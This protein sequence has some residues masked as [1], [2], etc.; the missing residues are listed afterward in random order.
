[1][2]DA[3]QLL[4]KIASLRMRLDQGVPRLGAPAAAGGTA[5]IE[6][7][8]RLG[9]WHN[10]LLDASLRTPDA[11]ADGPLPSRLTARGARVLRQSRELL[12]ALRALADDPILH[13]DEDDPLALLHHDC[14]ALLEVV[15][16][17][18]QAFP[19]VPSV[20]LRLCEGLE[21]VLS[22][23]EE[24]MA[25][26]RTALTHRRN[27]QERIDYLAELLRRL[28]V[29]QSVGLGPLQALAD[30]VAEEAQAGLPLRFLTAGPDD[31]ARFAAAHGL[32]TAQVL[33]RL[34]VHEADWQT[35]VQTALMAALVHDVGMTRVPADIL[36]QPGPLSDGQR[37]LVERHPALGA[38]MVASLWPGGGWPTEA[39]TDHH[40]RLDGTGYPL[41]RKD[42]Q[43]GSFARLLAACD[44]YAALCTA[45]P[46]RAAGDTR[47][48]LTD[49]LLMAEHG[50]LDRGCTDRLLLLSFF[51][52][53]SAV[54]LDDGAVAVVTG[55][56]ADPTR[57]MVQLVTDARGVPL[58]LPRALD[59]ATQPR[60]AVARSLPRSERRRVLLDKFPQ[61]V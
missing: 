52:I 57:P 16:R 1:M 29:G 21:V 33:A 50:L 25:V 59:L 13:G 60:R 14:A 8:V 53:G 47:T 39:V 12:H 19:P 10:H 54:E 27:E 45:R 61:L 20:Q 2:S 7:Q 11:G 24:Q 6:E 15:L 34:I 32:T 42:I 37:R 51:P 28:A 3:K 17:G 38:P 55:V 18:V 49:T 30:R 4:Q 40:E 58:A 56:G 9:A 35:R 23:V 44:V 22:R 5:S 26:L 31:P 46:H 36:A 43:V 48:A 41:G